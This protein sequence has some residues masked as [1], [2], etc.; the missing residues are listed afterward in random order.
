MSN[1]FT[2]GYAVIVGVG[3]DL[4]NTIGDATGIADILKDL[5]RCAYPPD[6]VQLL[7]G[8]NATR[9]AILGSLGNLAQV[10]DVQAT[11]IIYFSGHGYRVTSPTGEF[12]LSIAIW[13]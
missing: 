8:G 5:E 9:A 4:P 2:Q 1:V 12:L 3:G 13:L 6:H 11:V 10:A 7:T